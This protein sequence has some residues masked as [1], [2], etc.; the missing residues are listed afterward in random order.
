[1]EQEEMKVCCICGK[2]F[3]GWGNN[4]WP[5][6]ENGECCDICNWTKVVPARVKNL[7]NQKP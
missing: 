3:K 5:V 7:K 4:P 1:M 6:R 2:V